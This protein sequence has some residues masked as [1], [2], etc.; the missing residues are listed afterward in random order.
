[1]NR[2][3]V[4]VAAVVAVAVAA[5]V[6]WT[7]FFPPA[8][9]GAG[10]VEMAQPDPLGDSAERLVYLDQGWSESDRDWFYTVSQGSWIVPYSWWLVLEDADGEGRFGRDE[11]IRRWRYVP[12]QVSSRNPDGLP[13]GF[14]KDED[15]DWMG[16][17]CAACHTAQFTY[18]GA[19][20]RID[21]G[22]TLG[23]SATMM[24]E[25]GEALQALLDDDA[26]FA[27]FAANVLGGEATDAD[28]AQLHGRVGEVDASTDSFNERNHS[29]VPWGYGRVDALG[30]I[31]NEVTAR[32]LGIPENRREPDA[33]VSFP[34]LWDAPQHDRVQWNGALDNAGLGSMARNV[35]E[36]LGVWGT[37]DIDPQ[38]EIGYESTVRGM[39]LLRIEERLR[40]LVSPQWSETPLPPV[41]EELAALGRP[42]YVT[43]CSGCHALL[44]GEERTSP[45]RRIEAVMI[46]AEQI[47]TD[48]LTT[49][50]FKTR[51]ARTGRLEGQKLLLHTG[52]VLGA[53]AQAFYVLANAALGIIFEHPVPALGT[54]FDR[55]ALSVIDIGHLEDLAP[56]LS[57]PDP[58]SY[59]AR[60]LNGVWA[61]APFLHNGSVPNLTELLTAPE[62]RATTFYVGH[63]EFDPVNVG[64]VNESIPG[65]F[66][67][68]TTQRGNSNAGH[69]HG[70]GLTLEEKRQLI[71]FLKTQ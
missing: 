25:L 3:P 33:P 10:E 70:T 47:G 65:A 20:V 31:L 66:V 19:A 62:E 44:E 46:P 26:K 55:E 58:P 37:V 15:E 49:T 63:T 32:D 41:D 38:V 71:E 6:G 51:T 23:D 22:P 60:P 57:V 14:V 52:E 54:V 69:D 16:F 53:E 24:T 40:E 45:R 36:V 67:Y 28:R 1:M 30:T 61:T 27:R 59:K 34:F 21:G 64:Y 2:K 7:Y 48:P 4:I 39:N 50:N 9:G 29:T 13:L 8:P 5:Y 35:G 11:N 68:D 12:N 43:H 42:L 17:N 18:Q 56:D